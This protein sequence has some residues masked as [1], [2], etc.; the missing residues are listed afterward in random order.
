MI[1]GELVLRESR[2]LLDYHGKAGA[3]GVEGAKERRLKE[4]ISSGVDKAS[5]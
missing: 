1:Y 2:D 5:P 3:Q 4:K